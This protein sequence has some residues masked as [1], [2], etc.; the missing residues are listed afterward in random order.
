MSKQLLYISLIHENI[1]L[2]ATLDQ[3]QNPFDFKKQLFCK[4]N[5]KTHNQKGH[6]NKTQNNFFFIR[7]RNLTKNAEVWKQAQTKN[8]QNTFN[9]YVYNS[10]ELR[11]QFIF[12]DY[13][14]L[15]YTA[16]RYQQALQNLLFL[17]Q[18]QHDMEKYRSGNVQANKFYLQLCHLTFFIVIAAQTKRFQQ[19]ANEGDKYQSCK[20]V[21]Q[22]APKIIHLIIMKLQ[23]HFK[24]QIP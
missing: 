6:L 21:S 17:E 14:A 19:Q 23:N 18:Y 1:L 10:I 15:S 24:Y 2:F 4:N 13:T 22:N 11:T 20:T 5:S 16:K 12:I 8:R 3:S 7:N 9:D